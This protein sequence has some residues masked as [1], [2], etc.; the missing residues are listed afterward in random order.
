MK[1]K[2]SLQDSLKVF[3]CSKD[4]YVG[5]SATNGAVTLAAYDGVKHIS[6]SSDAEVI[7]P[8]N[9]VVSAKSLALIEKCVYGAALFSIKGN[10]IV[11]TGPEGILSIPIIP[12]PFPAMPPKKQ[13]GSVTLE[14]ARLKSAVKKVLFAAG[15]HEAAGDF[16]CLKVVAGSGDLSITA[17]DKRTYAICRLPVGSPYQGVFFIPKDG[18]KVVQKIEGDMLTLTFCQGA[19]GFSAVSNVAVD[20]LIPEYAGGRF[21]SNGDM[22]G[23][24]PKS[25]LRCD[26]SELASLLSAAVSVS[27]EL[28]ITFGYSSGGYVKEP[29]R[30]RVSNPDGMAFERSPGF[31]WSGI[32]MKIKVNAKTLLNAVENLSGGVKLFFSGDLMPNLIKSDDGEFTAAIMTYSSAEKK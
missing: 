6:C 12:E 5:I 11:V 19:L 23:T 16:N 17:C 27:E 29:V 10:K 30:F 22:L 14:A 26:A 8:G 18:L 7:Q 32:E 31:E 20:I 9:A 25:E 1:F 24:I 4:Y 21:P 15:I 2:C 28:A 13:A 3:D